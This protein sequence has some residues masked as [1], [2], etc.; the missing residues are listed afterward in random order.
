MKGAVR[1]KRLL[2]EIDLIDYA[3]IEIDYAFYGPVCVVS[4]VARLRGRAGSTSEAKL[5]VLEVYAQSDAPQACFPAIPT[6]ATGAPQLGQR[7]PGLTL[8]SRSQ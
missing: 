5:R 2:D 4:Y 8:F 3:M 1:V 6:P 7:P